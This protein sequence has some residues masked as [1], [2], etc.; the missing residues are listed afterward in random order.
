MPSHF[1]QAGRQS[2]P[3]TALRRTLGISTAE[4]VVAELV[5]ACAGQTVLV[6][7]ALHLGASPLTVALVVAL[8]QVATIAQLPGAWAVSIFGRKRVAIVTLCL[9]RQLILPLALVPFLD[10]RPALAKGLLLLLSSLASL[11]AV[12][13][14]NA[15]TSWMGELVPP[16]IRGRYFGVR[17]AALTVGASVAGLLVAIAL[18]RA[19]S[20]GWTGMALSAFT[21]LSCAFGWVTVV[22]LRRQHDPGLPISPTPTLRAALRPLFDP[23]ARSVLAYQV[24]WN[25][26]VGLAAGYFTFHMLSNMRAGFLL[27]AL[28]AA[29]GAGSKVLSSSL[30]GRAIDELGAR[31]VLA[32]CSFVT[33]ILPLLW[34]FAAP[35]VLWP[36]FLDGILT[37]VF[38][39]GQTL[40]SFALPL[41]VSPRRD[42]PFYLAVFAMAGGLAF[43]ASAMVGG[44]LLASMPLS[45][46]SLGRGQAHS[47]DLAFIV[48]AGCRIAAAFLASRIAERGAGSFLELRTWAAG[49]ARGALALERERA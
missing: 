41:T 24:A 4:G 14:N 46:T 10:L 38:W 6:G 31:P 18:D 17:T 33:A 36:V 8:P 11:L 15:W 5:G 19:G 12:A 34:L 43:F 27:V 39:G 1:A 32:V 9:S 48:S 7:W 40:A 22:L 28:N 37:G 2:G 13:G 21:V 35:G 20:G 42:R 29:L 45:V 44:V 26:A 49:I 30:W 16:R 47:V 25:A 23:A 3:R